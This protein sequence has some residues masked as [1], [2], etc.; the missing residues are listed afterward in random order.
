LLRRAG[1]L[2]SLALVALVFVSAAFLPERADPAATRVLAAFTV[3]LAALGLALGGSRAP[4][5]AGAGRLP[6]AGA[7][8]LGALALYDGQ[9]RW[10][11]LLP[12]LVWACV[13]LAFARSLGESQSLVEQLARHIDRRA[14]GFIAPYCRVVTQIYVVLF[15]GSAALIAGLALFGTPDARR[16]FSGVGVWI[17]LAA[18]QGAEFL[19]RKL[20]FRHYG[21]N[22]IDRLLARCFPAERTERGR[23]SMAHLRGL[24]PAEAGGPMHTEAALS[25]GALRAHP[26]VSLPAPF[27]FGGALLLAWLLHWRWPLTLLHGPAADLIGASLCA[28]VALL[29]VRG[30]RAF[31]SVGT[32]IRPDRPVAALVTTGPFAWSR[33]PIYLALALLLVSLGIWTRNAWLLV[34]LPPTLLLVT[35]HVIRREEAYL[36]QRFGERYQRY[37]ERVPRWL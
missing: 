20:H 8:V 23:R 28:V 22:P 6:G 32:P 12:A 13:A 16:F 33:N 35:R 5:L 34:L 15:A 36:C 26:G 30:V 4:W 25:A 29:S 7:L 3:L 11:A 31:R 37:R 24:A 27:Y 10:L 9:Q 2:L 19:V 17:G 14:P 1:S 18:F 21:A